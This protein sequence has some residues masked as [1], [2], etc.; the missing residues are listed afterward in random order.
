M[1]WRILLALAEEERKNNRIRTNAP[2]VAI[3]TAI[4]ATNCF[5]KHFFFFLKNIYFKVM[6][7]LATCR[8][9]RTV[10]RW[11]RR[12]WRRSCTAIA[13]ASWLPEITSFQFTCLKP[14]LY[15]GEDALCSCSSA[16]LKK[17][18]DSDRLLAWVVLCT[19]SLKRGDKLRESGVLNLSRM[20]SQK[21]RK[22]FHSM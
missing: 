1:R 13:A 6:K 14:S 17:V 8:W 12:F 16:G 22:P 4:V 2:P 3:P 20:R 21:K 9:W 7:Q 15:L 19:L 11:Y 10:T 5:L 18:V